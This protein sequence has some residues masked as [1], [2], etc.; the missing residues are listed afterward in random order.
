MLFRSGINLAQFRSDVVNA[1]SNNKP[2]SAP[3]PAPAKPSTPSQHDKA[4]AATKPKHQGN[5]W[6][7]LDYFNGHGKDQIRVAGWLVP[8]KPQGP[9]GKYAYVIFMQHGTGKELTRVQS[10]GIKRPDVKK[11]YGYQGRSEER[12]VG[13]ECRSRWSPYH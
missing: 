9:I 2:S 12:R 5:A 3:K 13:K 10:A 4:V 6:G 1:K 11:A 8:D 7:K